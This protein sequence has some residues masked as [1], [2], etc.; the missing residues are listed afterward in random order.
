[1]PV[2]IPSGFCQATYFFEAVSLPEGATIVVG[3]SFPLGTPVN[4]VAATLSEAFRT[5]ML[6]HADPSMRF[7]ETR[8]VANDGGVDLAGAHASNDPGEGASVNLLPP[9]NAALV[10]KITGFVGRHQHG[11][12]YL[13]S[14]YLPEGFVSDRGALDVAWH[15]HLQD[16]CDDWFSALQTGSVDMYLLHQSGGNPDD[17]PT[18][19]N[20]LRVETLVATQRRRLHR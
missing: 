12:V 20:Q 10:K 14:P 3:H 7:V 13:P 5:T 15:D 4:D 16:S 9:N 11:R 8:V 18:L 2:V 1:M 17:V 19:V 6:A